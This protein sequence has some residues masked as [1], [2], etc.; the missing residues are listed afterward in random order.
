MLAITCKGCSAIG[1][2]A[3][4]AEV[5]TLKLPGCRCC[6]LVHDHDAAANAGF[7]CRPVHIEA[8]AGFQHVALL[9]G[10]T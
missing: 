7:I 6:P 10:G 3:T 4:L 8:P 1:F 5:G 9:G 2:V